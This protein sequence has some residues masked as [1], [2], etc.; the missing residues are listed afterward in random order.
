MPPAD[1]KLRLCIVSKS[2][3]RCTAA[4]DGVGFTAMRATS[5]SPVVMPP[6]TPPW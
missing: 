3:V 6:I 4:M 2:S 5:G 1:R